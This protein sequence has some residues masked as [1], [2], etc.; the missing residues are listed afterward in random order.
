MNIQTRASSTRIAQSAQDDRGREA[1][2]SQRGSPIVEDH[3][4]DGAEGAG[5]SQG[6]HARETST[7]SGRG[8]REPR[9]TRTAVPLPDTVQE[10]NAFL[11]EQV[12]EM[13]LQR[14]NELL[15]AELLGA[16]EGPIVPIDGVSLPFRGQS[17]GHKHKLSE[18]DRDQ[19]GALKRMQG[20]SAKYAG[21]NLK[22]LQDFDVKWQNK[23]A[24]S[25]MGGTYPRI[26]DAMRISIASASLEDIAA[27]AWSKKTELEQ[28][29]YLT[30]DD[31]TAYLRTIVADPENRLAASTLR[32]KEC[33]QKPGQTA[34]QLQQ[35][36]DELEGDIPRDIT[37]ERRRAYQL[38]NSL[39]PDLRTHV[40]RQQEKITTVESVLVIASRQEQLPST[41]SNPQRDRESDKSR[42]TS[43]SSSFGRR[44]APSSQE[45][46]QTHVYGKRKETR[47]PD[48][49]DPPLCWYCNKHGH[50]R[51]D[52]EKKKRDEAAAASV[53]HASVELADR[54]SNPPRDSG[55]ARPTR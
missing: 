26:P 55:K 34:R 27:Y 37:D 3:S 24:S 15:E 40:L 53:S 29:S 35:F 14:E 42:S 33:R 4:D 36:I 32:L 30:W 1:G 41:S 51:E 50:R 48:P 16:L 11:R 5:G 20:A 47:R 28:R 43:S 52:C 54:V 13:R 12:R 23:F 2:R 18:H 21:R 22:E 46:R 17:A 45:N 31:W 10:R 39:R 9:A 7:F 19:M 38:L 6:R 8:S 25:E 49:R 44:N